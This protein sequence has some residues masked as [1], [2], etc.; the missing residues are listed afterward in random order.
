MAPPPFDPA[1]VQA[2]VFDIG[3]VFLIPH[4]EPVRAALAESGLDVT[5]DEQA[6]HEAH[7]RGVRAIAEAVRDQE[8][9][10][11]EGTVDVWRTYDGAYFSTVGIA[12]HDLGTAAAARQRQRSQG[13]SNVW[14]QPMAENIAAFHRLAEARP[15]LRRAIVS[16]NDG[17]AEQQMLEHSVCQVGPGR[18]PSVEVLVDS[19]VI[20]IAKPDPAIFEPVHELLPVDPANMLYIGDTF[21][22]DV[23]GAE[24]AGMQVV[25]L[26]PYDLHADFDHARV[27]D[28]SALISVLA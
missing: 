23:L 4:H 22:S 26:D 12:D 21:Q 1:A 19:G 3:G 11:D 24:A 27:G 28:L 20:G 25:Q 18:L 15:D 7:H 13:V 8:I 5:P 17:T 9:E 14:S 6:F 16:N 10:P 2:V